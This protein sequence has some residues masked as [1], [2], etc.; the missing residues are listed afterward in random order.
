MMPELYLAIYDAVKR[1]DI[2]KAQQIQN[3]AC[4]I[5]YA[6]CGCHGNMYAVIKK[7]M[8]LREGLS[9]GGVRKPLANLVEA[10]MPK[11]QECVQMIDKAVTLC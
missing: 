4:R 3:E 11:V 8:D 9:L 2:P 5:I 7:V 10:D 1:G 6:L